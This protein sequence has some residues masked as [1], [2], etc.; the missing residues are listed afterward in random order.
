M[1]L[2]ETSS[3]NKSVT[4]ISDSP[5]QKPIIKRLFRNPKPNEFITINSDDSASDSSLP[6]ISEIFKRDPI[7]KKESIS[8]IATS[9]TTTTTTTATS[10]ASSLS[11]IRDS[12]RKNPISKS[13]PII[14]NERYILLR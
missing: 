2:H 3:G 8:R 12:M 1:T 11:I 5:P 9:H 13:K 10:S 6:S 7:V 14:K 4:I